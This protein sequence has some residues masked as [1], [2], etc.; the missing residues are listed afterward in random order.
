MKME[1]SMNKVTVLLVLLGVLCLV[2]L[3]GMNASCKKVEPGYVGIKVKLYGEQKGVQDFTVRTGRVWINPFSEELYKFPTFIQNVVW[4]RNPTE[5]SSNDESITFNSKEGAAINA[6]VGVAYSIDGE[7]VPQLFVDLR[8]PAKYITD[9]YVRSQVRDA[10]SLEASKMAVMDIFGEKKQELLSNVTNYLTEKLSGRGFKFDMVSFVGALRVEKRVT[11][12]I[13]QAIQATQKAIEAEN[14]T[15]EIAAEADQKRVKAQGEADA[16]RLRAQ[17]EANAI[18]MVAEA[19]ADAN[20]KLNESLTPM[21]LKWEATQK[22]NGIM[23]R[24][25]GGVLPFIDVSED[26]RDSVGM[27]TGAK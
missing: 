18:Q 8:K 20:R 24:V 17:A 22:W 6:D 27:S 25:T 16:E 11:D 10:F 14:R 13:N 15:R 7:K 23:P 12:A 21:L 26:A 1:V 19:K 4:T 2:L 3:V 5:G 9:V